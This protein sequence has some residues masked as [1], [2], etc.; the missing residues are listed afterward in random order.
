MRHAPFAIG[1][2]ERDRWL[3]HMRAAVDAMDPP[4]DVAQALT[5]YFTLASDAL[6][7]QPDER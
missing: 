5:D 4:S 1:S 2:D 3:V 6:R 7:N